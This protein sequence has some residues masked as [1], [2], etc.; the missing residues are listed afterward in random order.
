M[1][2]WMTVDIGVLPGVV[3]GPYRSGRKI[4]LVTK[5][6]GIAKFVGVTDAAI[7]AAV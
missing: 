5:C 3:F 2:D 6:E 7:S 1:A 4:A